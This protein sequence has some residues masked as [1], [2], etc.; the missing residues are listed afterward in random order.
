[1]KKERQ[2]TDD[3]QRQRK[4]LAEQIA[5]AQATSSSS[6]S[7]PDESVAAVE[8]G[9]VRPEG[10]GGEKVKLAFTFGKKAASPPEGSSTTT[11]AAPTATTAGGGPLKMSFNPLKRPAPTANVFKSKPLTSSS[12]ATSVGGAGGGKMSATEALMKEDAERKRRLAERTGPAFPPGG[13]RLKM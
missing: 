2:D 10:E 7:T 4:L 3:E 8:A 11:T 1:M 13:K 5:R 6:T 12:T 9:L